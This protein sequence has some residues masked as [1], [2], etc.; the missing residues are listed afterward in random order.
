MSIESTPKNEPREPLLSSFAPHS[1]ESWQKA[2][3]ALLKGKDLASLKTRLPEGITL[4]PVYR[5]KD[6]QTLSH[7]NT[8]PGDPGSVR[9]ARPEGYLQRHWVVS[10]SMSE[11]RADDCN[12]ALQEDLSRGLDEVALALDVA[13]RAGLDADLAP[14]SDVGVG[15]LS[16]STR[17]DLDHALVDVRLEDTPIFIQAGGASLEGAA[18]LLAHSQQR[19]VAAEALTGCLACDPL[20]A[21]ADGEL[22]TT[23]DHALNEMSALLQ[24]AAVHAPK[25]QTILIGASR[26]RDAGAHVVQELGYALA[27]GVAYLRAAQDRGLAL[28]DTARSM[29]FEFAL[30]GHFFTEIA[31]LRAARHVWSKVLKAFG[32]DD[33]PMMMHARTAR[34]NKT[35]LDPYV[36]MLRGTTEAFSAIVGG[37]DGLQVAPFDD[38]IRPADEFSRRTARNTQLVLAEECD[39]RQ[40]IDPAGGSYYVEKL[41]DAIGRE[42]WACLQEIEA[43]GGMAEALLHGRIQEAVS[44]VA[45]EEQAHLAQ[46]RAVLVGT[47]LYAN[48]EEEPL[49]VPALDHQALQ[50]ER[51][52]ALKAQREARDEQA[53]KD[54]L[55]ALK[56]ARAAGSVELMPLA[57]K[58]AVAGATLGDLSA[59][60]PLDDAVEI[61]PLLPRRA[62]EGFEALRAAALAHAH[63]TGR[64]P[65]V[66]LL[67]LGASRLY[68][69]RADW[70]AGFF[71]AGGFEVRAE[72]DFESVDEALSAARDGHADVLV[73][74]STDERYATDVGPLAKAL[75]ADLSSPCVLVAGAPGAHE[76]SWRQGGVEG[77]VHIKLNL[78]ET[79]G[80]LFK[81]VGV[82]S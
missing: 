60:R 37:V 45:D 24:F 2:A 65:R 40:V 38:A 67:N 9:G 70:T 73:I 13:S 49:V 78:L 26:Y 80:N 6:I 61:A 23:L 82:L 18:L 27:T 36:N 52:T 30:G 7:L 10:Q 21:M 3:E 43:R 59:T 8:T 19:G 31:K 22:G 62:A 35:K 58:A 34:F 20:G 68:R 74:V 77:F 33:T 14:T 11:P 5:A 17:F 54:S 28:G 69:A 51:R 16:L 12:A 81:K 55:T 79:L 64:R 29:R 66:L 76:A 39:L 71:A 32:V 46:R 48:T 25:M 56:S 63:K 50:N 75:H 72:R 15:G 1:P 42:A 4:E 41:T 47:N 44:A 57:L 53:L